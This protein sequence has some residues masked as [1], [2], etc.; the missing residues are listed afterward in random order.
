MS[1]VP[2]WFPLPRIKME[3]LQVMMGR[4]TTQIHGPESTDLTGAE[5]GG[6][7]FVMSSQLGSSPQ[8]DNS[9]SRLG[10]FINLHQHTNIA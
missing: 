6:A 4:S 9:F 10:L 8:R 1:L 5:S 3:T 7:A 2:W